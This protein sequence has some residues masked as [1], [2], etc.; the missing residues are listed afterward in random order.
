MRT[1]HAISTLIALLPSMG[2]ASPLNSLS[3]R[4]DT[5]NN[6]ILWEDY[7]DLDVIRVGDVYYYSSS[8]FAFSPGAPILKSYDLVNWTP[9]SHSVPRLDFASN[10]DLPSSSQ[11]AYVKGIWASTLRYRASSDTFF[12]LGCVQST[13]KTYV[14]TASGTQAGKNGG[15]VS[16]WNWQAKATL[17]RCYYDA[18]M[19]I[20][21]DN[22][23]YVAYGNTKI[24]VAQLNSDGTAEVKNQQV[25]A[26]PDGATIEGSRMYKIN[27]YYYIFVSISRRR[28]SKY[29]M[30]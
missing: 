3:A 7:P 28:K 13:G 22:T 15:E 30:C 23:M 16:G 17:P 1:W 10:Y 4:A 9:V 20:D 25:Y 5:F 8:T 18:G 14:Y 12:W 6:P 26:S 24:S 21:D 29:G 2:L 27:G 19:L 11:R